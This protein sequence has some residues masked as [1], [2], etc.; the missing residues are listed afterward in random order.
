MCIISTVRRLGLLR[1]SGVG[2][3]F[4][5]F[6]LKLLAKLIALMPSNKALNAFLPKIPKPRPTENKLEKNDEE[7]QLLA[8]LACGSSGRIK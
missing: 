4:E 8:H 7:V 1:L 6:K 2:Y 3:E 5:R